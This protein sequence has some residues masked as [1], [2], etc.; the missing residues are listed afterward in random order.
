MFKSQVDSKS[1][2]DSEKFGY[3]LQLVKPKVRERLA[4]L[5]P[6]ARTRLQDSMAE[7]KGWIWTRH[8]N[9]CT[10]WRNYTVTVSEGKELWKSER[11]LWDIMQNFDALE[12]MGEISMLKEL[13]VSTLNK[14]PNVKPDMARMDDS[15]EDWDMKQF[16]LAIQECRYYSLWALIV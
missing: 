5:R 14:L 4:N 13:V 8:D 9:C 1:I 12:T 11:V 7:A 16:I 10:H 2:S 6:G 3:L 15:W